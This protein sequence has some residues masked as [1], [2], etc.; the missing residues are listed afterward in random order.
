MMVSG[1]YL[2][3]HARGLTVITFPRSRKVHPASTSIPSSV[4]LSNSYSGTLAPLS[5]S[6]Y[7][8]K[9]SGEFFQEIEWLSSMGAGNPELGKLAVSAKIPSSGLAKIIHCAA[10]KASAPA[11]SRCGSTSCATTAEHE[12]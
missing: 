11:R 4:R 5:R 1:Q 10:C 8:P 12:T 3:T 9:R 2:R 7:P 6:V